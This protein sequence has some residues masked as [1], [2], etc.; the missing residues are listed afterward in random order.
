MALRILIGI[1]KTRQEEWEV[2]AGITSKK[3]IYRYSVARAVNDIG[4]TKKQF[5]EALAIFKGKHIAYTLPTHNLHIVC[6]KK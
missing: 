5:Q 2:V 1:P 4:V 3:S 6:S